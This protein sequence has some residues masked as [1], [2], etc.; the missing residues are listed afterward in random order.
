MSNVSK[1]DIDTKEDQLEVLSA[2]KAFI[3]IAIVTLIAIVAGALVL[4]A[5]LL[6]FTK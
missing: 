5:V 1:S 6:I 2:G 3:H 4:L